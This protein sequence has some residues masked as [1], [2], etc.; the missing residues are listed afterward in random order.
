MPQKRVPLKDPLVA[1]I[2]A[3]LL[4]GLGHLYQRRTF[5]AVIYCVC[6]LGVFF[7]GFRIGYGQVVYVQWSDPETRTY[8]YL[9]QAGVGLPA[10]PALAQAKLRSPES[11]RPNYVSRSFRADFT[12][13]LAGMEGVVTA[14][15][16]FTSR[17]RDQPRHWE[18]EVKG[19]IERGQEQVPLE[20]KLYPGWLEPAVAPSKRRGVSGSFEGTVGGKPVTM[21]LVGSVP[22]SIWNW[23]QAPLIDVR[24]NEESDQSALD[25]AHRELGSRFELGVVY[26]MIAGLLNVLAIFDAVGGP[27]YAD[28]EEQESSSTGQ[29]ASSA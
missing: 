4:P 28:E 10:L 26:T 7:A 14:Q 5:K 1:G 9:C 22:R 21:R 29:A 16:D 24:V 23:Y 11:L 25:Q 19:F 2:L 13:E 27:A 3:F 8:A 6:I 20:G 12:G 18:G 15:I 17:H